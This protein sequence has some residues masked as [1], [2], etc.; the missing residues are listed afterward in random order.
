VALVSTDVA[1]E[2][3]HHPSE[4]NQQARN[5]VSTILFTLMMEAA[6]SSETSV[7]TRASH[8]IPEDGILYSHRRE[9]RNSYVALSGWPL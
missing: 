5:S 6:H 1:E 4:K 8:H 7:L 2:H 3:H 9:N